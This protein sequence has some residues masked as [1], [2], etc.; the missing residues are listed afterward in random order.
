MRGAAPQTFDALV[1]ASGHYWDPEIPELPGHFD[2]ARRSRARLPHSG[3]F[4]GQRVVVVGGEPVRARHRRRGRDDR[5]AHRFCRAARG[6]TSCPGTCSGGRST[7]STGRPAVPP[8]ARPALHAARDAARRQGDAGPREPSA[9][10]SAGSSSNC[11]KWGC[12]G[13]TNAAKG[14]PSLGR[15]PDRHSLLVYLDLG[16][17]DLVAVSSSAWPRSESRRSSRRAPERHA[18]PLQQLD[19]LRLVFSAPPRSSLPP[20]VLLPWR[21]LR[22]VGALL[23]L[24]GATLPAFFSAALISSCS[25][26]ASHHLVS[27]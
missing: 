1:M 20:L 10:L 11:W 7:S 14:P 16:A 12:C 4:A 26:T 21:W 8:P 25:T 5:R 22:S 9:D 6:T 19:L 15:E 24:R 17:V 2:G 27:S 13:S 23:G 18:R 3:P